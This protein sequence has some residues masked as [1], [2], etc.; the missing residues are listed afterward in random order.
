VVYRFD[1]FINA[2]SSASGDG[3]FTI[4]CGAVTDAFATLEHHITRSS[5]TRRAQQRIAADER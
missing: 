2:A 4:R 5:E 3:E 1:G